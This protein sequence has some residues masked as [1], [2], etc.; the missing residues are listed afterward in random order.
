[1]LTLH[2]GKFT[3]DGGLYLLV[4]T[5]ILKIIIIAQFIFYNPQSVNFS[6]EVLLQ[7][8]R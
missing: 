7:F 1:M 4:S 2:G 5:S 3:L 6:S 8:F